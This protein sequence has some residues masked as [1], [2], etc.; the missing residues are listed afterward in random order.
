M[1]CSGEWFFANPT[2]NDS[3]VTAI[4]DRFPKQDF[5]KEIETCNS[6][7]LDVTLQTTVA[8]TVLWL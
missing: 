7:R 5:A 3:F 4:S 6:N 8:A 1:T 2:G